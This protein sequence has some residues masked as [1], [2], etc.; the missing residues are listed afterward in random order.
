MLGLNWEF[1][2]ILIL[3]KQLLSVKI[4]LGQETIPNRKM[5]ET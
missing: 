2:L 4:F 3:F 5:A 1:F